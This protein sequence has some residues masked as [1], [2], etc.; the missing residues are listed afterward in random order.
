MLQR[1]Y[2]IS[3]S[4]P[5]PSTTVFLTGCYLDNTIATKKNIRFHWLARLHLS[6]GYQCKHGSIPEGGAWNDGHQQG[7]WD[8]VQVW[9]ACIQMLSYKI[10]KKMYLGINLSGAQNLIVIQDQATLH[11]HT[12][13]AS[14]AP[15]WSWSGCLIYAYSASLA[16]TS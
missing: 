11:S 2:E 12:G 1:D 7:G 8:Y 10:E 6:E 3:V 4:N 13:Q 14:G 16:D 9:N 5:T 15:C